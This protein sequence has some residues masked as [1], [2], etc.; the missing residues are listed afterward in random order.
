VTELPMDLSFDPASFSGRVPLFPLPNVVLLPGGVLPLHVFEPRYVSMVRDALDGERFLSMALLKPGYEPDYEGR[1]AIEPAT[2]LGR[3]VM[4]EALA[5]GRWNLVLLG[6]RRA[7][8]LEEDHSRPYRVAAVEIQED[9]VLD[10][11]LDA[12]AERLVTFLEDVPAGVV[13]DPSRIRAAA[14]LVRRSPEQLGLF[15][16]LAADVILLGLKDRLRVL[17]T[18]D[19]ISRLELLEELVAG[20][21]D[22]V[23]RN[24]HPWPPRFSQN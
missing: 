4:E 12:L 23:E 17:E 11:R 16:D 2:C 6:L 3:I 13:R 18:T 14:K 7:A 20:R 9:E 22:E 19:V 21:R 8:V 10:D 24:R 5:D 15:M 1:P